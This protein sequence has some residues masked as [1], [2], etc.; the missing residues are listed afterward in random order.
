MAT[1]RQGLWDNKTN[2]QEEV[3]IT[4]IS[5]IPIKMM[6]TLPIDICIK[7]N[8]RLKDAYLL[9]SWRLGS[10]ISCRQL[11]NKCSFCFFSL[12]LQN[13]K[14]VMWSYMRFEDW[15]KSFNE[16]NLYLTAHF[17]ITSFG[18]IT[19]QRRAKWVIT[20]LSLINYKTYREVISSSHALE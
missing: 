17:S 15:I 19:L 20:Q 4:P 12:F 13:R 8:T 10:N 2:T 11:N 7:G 14:E 16:W 1:I 5:W 6:M 18:R 3:Q 9:V